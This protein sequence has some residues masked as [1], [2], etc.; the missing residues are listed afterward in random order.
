MT[1]IIQ[2][3][4]GCY[5]ACIASITGIPLDEVPHPVESDFSPQ[6]WCLYRNTLVRFLRYRGWWL[7]YIPVATEWGPPKGYAII[8]G[9]SPR[10]TGHSCVALDGKIIHDPH[11]EG[12]GLVTTE[13]YEV[14]IEL[15]TSQ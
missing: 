7:A 5:A 2:K 11:P 14:L 10:G 9:N 3:P 8:S 1:P 6:A 4:N 15:V 13:E 12:G